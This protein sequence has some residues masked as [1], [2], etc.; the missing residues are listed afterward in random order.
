VTQGTHALQ[1][2]VN[3]ST[4]MFL[5]NI[6]LIVLGISF[7]SS[8]VSFRLDYSFCF[9]ALSLLLSFCFLIECIA[10]H[11]LWLFHLKS[12]VGL[13]SVT[14]LVEFMVYGY[15]FSCILTL[16]KVKKIVTAFLIIF[17]LFWFI[18]VFFVFG[19]DHWNSYVTVVGS[20]FIIFFC[21]AYYYQVIS[22][23]KLVKLSKCPEFWIA[24]GLLIFYGCNLPCMSLVN[25][26]TK[27]YLSLARQ[28]LTVLDLSNIVM[29]IM[30]S[31]AFLCQVKINTTK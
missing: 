26:I 12:N 25:F 28:L 1:Q 27:N 29:Y 20:I 8:L 23:E 3:K 14:M 16:K 5:A 11:G 7:L 10:M 30:F 4:I 22:D 21:I 9:K 19:F 13:Y 17:P 2:F 31:Y 18:V 15:F 6:Y 24:T